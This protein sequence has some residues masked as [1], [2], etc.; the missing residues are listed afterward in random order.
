MNINLKANFYLSFR[1]AISLLFGSLPLLSQDIHYSQYYHSPLTL[2]PALTGISKG[3][4][5]FTGIYRSQWSAANAPYKTMQAV[6]EKKFYSIAHDTWWL[7]GG[8]NVFY[9]RAGDGN[10]ATT[11]VSISGSYT[12]KLDR[13]NFLTAGLAAGAGQRRYESGN[14]TFDN[15]WNG[16]IFD[17]NRPIGEVLGDNNILYPDFS[18]G[19]NWRGQKLRTRS[20][21]DIGAGAFHF[22]RPNQNFLS[23]SGK[24]QLPIRISLY[25]LPTFQV[26]D[27]IDVVGHGNAQLQSK[28]LE[29]LAGAA[30]RLWLS[31]KKAKEVAVQ[32]GFTYRFNAIGDA[33]IPAAELQ[34]RDLM[35]GLSWDLN[36][37]G[38]SVAT[39]RN[40]GPEIAVRYILHKVYPLKAFKAC[41]LI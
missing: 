35:V 21:M 33:L 14:F 22:N 1:L 34:Y 30:A 29:A 24:D 2:S 9:D 36:V 28:D 10:F 18:V 37:S 6:A 12:R 15:Q 7:S 39:N 3:D 8:L 13:E 4:I 31:T 19:V 26:T 5:R 17:P 11:N 16:D 27:K 41:P 23:T 32:F 20:K 25:A 38:F 40:G